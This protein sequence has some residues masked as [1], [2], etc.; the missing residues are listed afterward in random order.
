[1]PRRIEWFASLH[2][3]QKRA[4][5]TRTP[6]RRLAYARYAADRHMHLVSGMM[7]I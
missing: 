1:M 5:Q 3:L 6:I 7:A 2:I 4:P